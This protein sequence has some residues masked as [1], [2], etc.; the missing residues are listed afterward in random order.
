MHSLCK[1]RITCACPRYRLCTE[2]RD[3]QVRRFADS[4]AGAQRGCASR[5]FHR[6]PAFLSSRNNI[7]RMG[8][9]LVPLR[10]NDVFARLHLVIS[11]RFRHVG[12]TG[13]GRKASAR[14]DLAR[15]TR[16]RADNGVHGAPP[17]HL[18][19]LRLELESPHP[20]RRDRSFPEER[21]IY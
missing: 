11:R 6:G 12:P 7:L 5:T 20:E 9:G 8:L 3:G 16:T 18:S 17:V 13:R 14:T 4:A 1:P 19:N 21:G 2:N 10:R 15:R